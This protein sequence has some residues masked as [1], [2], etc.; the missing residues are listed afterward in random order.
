MPFRPFAKFLQHCLKHPLYPDC[1]NLRLTM[2]L[3]TGIK[4]DKQN[5]LIRDG[6]LV[7]CEILKEEDGT[8]GEAYVEEACL[9][10]LLPKESTADKHDESCKIVPPDR[11]KHNLVDSD[12]DLDFFIEGEKPTP[13]EVVDGMRKNNNFLFNYFF[14]K[15]V[16]L[17][18]TCHS[19]RISN[20]NTCYLV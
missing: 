19:R 11:T 15:H 10:K 17:W 14:S 2:V 9:E 20:K 7:L 8:T 12:E 1:E 18:E 6:S 4:L 16:I 3:V 13:K 5:Q